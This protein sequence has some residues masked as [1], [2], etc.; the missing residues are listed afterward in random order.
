MRGRGPDR[1]LRSVLFV[2]GSRAQLV[3]KAVASGPDAVCVDLEDGVAPAAKAEA[4]RAV[5]DLLADRGRKGGPRPGSALFV[6]V[7][8]PDTDLGRDDL[9]ALA[10]VPAGLDGVLIPKVEE[11]GTVRRVG[12]ILGSAHP[13]LALLPM[14]ETPRSLAV[15]GEVAA[16][17]ARN[18][19]LVLGGVDLA[20]EL[21][22]DGSWESLLYARS[23][24]VHAAALAGIDAVDAPSMGLADREGLLDEA[25]R[26]RRLGFGGK[27]AVHPRQVAVIHEAYTPDREEVERARRFVE[28]YREA[29]E[30]VAVV[31]GRVVDRPVVASARRILALARA[32]TGGEGEP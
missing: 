9:E 26:A 25:G 8:A 21:G 15:A 20:A 4:R 1:L 5:V 29:G 23:R 6:R 12:E 13:D 32:G 18:R 2:P 11:P 16:A 10:G 27:L 28:A 3:P 22:A 17:S 24:I 30:G 14:V 31:D 7:N 19:A